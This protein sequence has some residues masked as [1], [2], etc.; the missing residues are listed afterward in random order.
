MIFCGMIKAFFDFIADAQF[1]FP[2]DVIMMVFLMG[3]IILPNLVDI[4]RYY[5]FPILN[6]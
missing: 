4:S 5:L 2:G 6:S 3:F 1:L